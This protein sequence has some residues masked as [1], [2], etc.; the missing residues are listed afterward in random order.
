[1]RPIQL[2][3]EGGCQCGAI[4][5]RI[6]Q[7]PLT[8]YACH[9]TE[10]QSQSGSGFG[11]SM[12]VPRDALKVEGAAPSS[13]SRQAASG[14]QVQCRFCKVC[15]TRLFHQPTRNP[16]VVNLKPGT[17]DVT[18]WLEPVA[19]LWTGSAQPWFKAP[20]DVI[21]YREQPADFDDLFQRWAERVAPRFA[22][23]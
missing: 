2:P 14:R 8:L 15:G 11:L 1:M 19:H 4:R 10:C 3:L 22:S 21:V 17:L 5:Y 16:D 13:W 6:T 7:A 18:D 20:D 9:C 23:I 12:P